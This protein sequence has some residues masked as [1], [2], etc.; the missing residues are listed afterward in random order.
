MITTTVLR[1]W[2]NNVHRQTRVF[3][4]L[5]AQISYHRAGSARTVDTLSDSADVVRW[6]FETKRS[7]RIDYNSSFVAKRS[8][9]QTQ[10]IK[11][12]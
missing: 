2:Y 4:A 9:D 6:L 11:P 5:R 7:D 1:Q 3:G 8:I 12:L 10:Y